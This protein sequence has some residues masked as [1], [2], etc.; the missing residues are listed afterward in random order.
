MNTAVPG[1][2]AVEVKVALMD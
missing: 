1:K 2:R